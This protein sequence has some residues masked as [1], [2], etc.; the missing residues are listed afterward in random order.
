VI[1]LVTTLEHRYIAAYR[2][3][4]REWQGD[5]D[6]RPVRREVIMLVTTLEQRYIA[7]YRDRVRE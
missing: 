4:V 7:A 6:R 2:D 3:R 1:M 5:R